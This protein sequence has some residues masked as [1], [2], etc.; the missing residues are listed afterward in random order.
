MEILIGMVLD[1]L[2]NIGFAVSLLA[3]FMLSNMAFSLWYNIKIVKEK[4]QIK[5]LIEGLFKII[6]FS[7]GLALLTIGIT[8]VPIYITYIGIEIKQEVLDLI[9]ISVIVY[10]FIDT[11]VFYEKQASETL[12]KILKTNTSVNNK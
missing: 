10:M 11:I 6:S 12:K 7:I 9:N 8:L 5:K 4:F 1:N 3:V 2:K